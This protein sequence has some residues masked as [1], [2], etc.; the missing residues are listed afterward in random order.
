MFDNN[1]VAVAVCFDWV[2]FDV[3]VVVVVLNVIVQVLVIVLVTV[4]L[5]NIFVIVVL[6]VFEFLIAN[7]IGYSCLTLAQV[8]V[9]TSIG[10]LGSV[11][12][13]GNIFNVITKEISGYS[14]KLFS[15]S[16]QKS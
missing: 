14:D 4:V 6:R 8:N 3:V 15:Y 7:I 16:P 2:G 12:L 11:E 10:C 5:I 9:T 13:N 1:V